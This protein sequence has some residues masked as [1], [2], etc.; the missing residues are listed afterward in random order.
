MIL[1]IAAR[2]HVEQD[3]RLTFLPTT[4]FGELQSQLSLTDPGRA[5]DDCQRS[6]YQAAPQGSIEFY[7][8]G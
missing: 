1:R 5:H 6:R 4:G 3:P 8:A 2:R 7:D